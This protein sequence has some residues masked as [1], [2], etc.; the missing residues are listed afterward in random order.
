MSTLHKLEVGK[1]YYPRRTVW[2]EGADYNYRSGVHE[3]RIFL[4]RPTRS[5]VE[6][7]RS[8]P[9]EFGFFAEPMGLML[10]TQ[11]GSRLSFDCSYSWHR[12]AE[13]TGDRTLPPAAVETSPAL[14]ALM[15][16]ILVE[17]TSGVVLV[18]RAVTFSPEFTRSL[19]RAITDQAGASYDRAEHQRWA[20]GMTARHSTDQLWERCTARC[21]GGA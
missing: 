19:H 7:I 21:Q 4:A 18:L 10:V 3:L 16:I 8:G 5:K 2:G 11:F 9:V 20:D 1:P 13:V 17:A 15:G 6:A 14:R 12:M